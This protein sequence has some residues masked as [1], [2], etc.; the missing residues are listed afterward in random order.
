MQIQ[1]THSL[2]SSLLRSQL[3][4]R[5]EV[6]SFQAYFSSPDIGSTVL[7]IH[8]V[9][10]RQFRVLLVGYDGGVGWKNMGIIFAYISNA[11]L[12]EMKSSLWKKSYHP[13]YF[14]RKCCT[15]GIILSRYKLTISLDWDIHKTS[16]HFFIMFFSYFFTTESKITKEVLNLRC[17]WFNNFEA[18]NGDEKKKDITSP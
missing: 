18:Q 1:L 10:W 11:E 13:P 6:I 3:E 12:D 4:I 14:F 9:W 7:H 2:F 16:W 5:D 15:C 8:M 17:G